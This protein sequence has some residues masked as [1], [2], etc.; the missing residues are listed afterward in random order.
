MFESGKTG[1]RGSR[2][3]AMFRQNIVSLGRY[4]IDVFSVVGQTGIMVVQ[5][6]R[7][8][9]ADPQRRLVVLRQMYHIGYLSLP[10][11]L[12]TGVSIGLVMAVQAYYTL[13]SLNAESMTGAMV[14]YAMVSQLMPVLTGLTLAGRVGSSIAAE[15]GTMKVTEQIDALRVMG[16]DPIAYLVAPRFL[17]CV[18]LIP[19]LTAVGGL[20]GIIAAEALVLSVWGVDPAAYWSHSE[21]LLSWWEVMTGLIKTVVYG[22]IIA[23]VS[24]RRGLRTEGGA[25]GVGEACTTAVVN[26]SMLI[27]VMTFVMTVLF[28]RLEH[29]IN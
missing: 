19:M 4:A 24:C 11:V 12:L 27:L 2:P 21:T 25:T 17:A 28:Q 26:S 7:S 23:L 16:T 1:G 6:L 14:N 20:V 10:V 29:F 13:N 22:A 15:I 9:V 8:F 5:V 3:G 18:M